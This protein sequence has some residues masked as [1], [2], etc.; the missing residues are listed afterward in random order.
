MWQ[1]DVLFELFLP[2]HLFC[3]KTPAEVLQT[4]S[5]GCSQILSSHPL[6]FKSLEFSYTLFDAS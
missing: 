6:C 4:G 5:S 1:A 3:C 2:S